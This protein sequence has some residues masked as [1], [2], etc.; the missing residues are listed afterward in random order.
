MQTVLRSPKD[1]NYISPQVQYKQLST[2][3]EEVIL[4]PIS[5]LVSVNNLPRVYND[6]SG[7]GYLTGQI[8]IVT[9][10]PFDYMSLCTLPKD[11]RPITDYFFP[12]KVI[13]G[14]GIVDNAIQV[15]TGGL[16]ISSAIVTV[17]GQYSV[18]PTLEVLGDGFG[19]SL[20][21]KVGVGFTYEASSPSGTPGTGYVPGDT[22]DLAGGTFAERAQVTITATKLVSAALNNPGNGYAPGDTITTVAVDGTTTRSTV[23]TVSTTQL[24]VIHVNFGG[25]G[26][27][28]NDTIVLNGGTYS[29]PAIAI[30]LTVSSGAITAIGVSS[31]G[32]YT[33]NSANL[34]QASSSGAGTGATFQNCQFGVRGFAITDGGHYTTNA[35]N[36]QQ[37]STSGSGSGVTFNTL[38]FG[39]DFTSI[40]IQGLYTAIPTNPVAQFSTS[41]SGT[42]ATIS[43][44]WGLKEVII[45]NAGVYV[46][47]PQVL[48]NGAHASPGEIYLGMAA[49][50]AGLV[51]L[52]N[53]PEA[54]DVICMDT[55]PFLMSK[56]FS[57]AG[58]GG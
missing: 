48:I 5:G 50:N 36:L 15:Q 18:I 10:D 57:G 26:Y 40:S 58:A 51:S 47:T 27:K 38:V 21:A 53:Q 3:W 19:A 45:N 39:A 55:P 30:V 42:G 56:A 11:M 12:V 13:R 8:T 28:V 2:N 1:E 24:T 31:G 29:N 37:S 25:V 9:D 54:N 52:V 43:V 7:F 23:M 49:N 35:V 17:P 44:L 16:G 34:T 22:I 33:V 46:S 14:S 20:A 6:G 32:T 41:G 4:N